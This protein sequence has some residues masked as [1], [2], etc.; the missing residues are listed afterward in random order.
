MCGFIGA[1]GGTFD[2][3]F[4][5]DSY[6]T[7]I[8]EADEETG[9]IMQKKQLIYIFQSQKAAWFAYKINIIPIKLNK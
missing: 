9:L 7:V 1:V 3:N 2:K 5:N 4:D 6:D 8:R